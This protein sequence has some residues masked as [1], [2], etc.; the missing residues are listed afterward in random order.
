MLQHVPQGNVQPN[1]LDVFPNLF[2]L[3]ENIQLLAA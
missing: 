1:S 2:W 3:K